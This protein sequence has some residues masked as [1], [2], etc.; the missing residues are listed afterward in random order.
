[1]LNFIVQNFNWPTFFI[2]L[3]V[4]VLISN[5]TSLIVAIIKKRRAYKQLNI[6]EKQYQDL[7]KQLKDNEAELNK[8]LGSKENK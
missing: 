7:Q 5:I 6:V 8:A 2:A 3:A 1:M 4:F